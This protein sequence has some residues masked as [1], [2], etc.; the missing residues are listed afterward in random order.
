M[1]D[2]YSELRKDHAQLLTM[3][4]ELHEGRGGSRLFTQVY[5]GLSA[6]LGAEQDTLYEE[7]LALP[8]TRE[9]ALESLV[10]H[11]LVTQLLAELTPGEPGDERWHATLAVLRVMVGRHVADEEGPMFDLARR[12]LSAERA[13]ALGIRFLAERARHLQLAVSHR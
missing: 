9:R 5:Q 1:A 11:R 4:F 13:E 10:E 3:L 8:P 7:L 6:H 2:I 12:S